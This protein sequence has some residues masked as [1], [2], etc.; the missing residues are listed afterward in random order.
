MTELYNYGPINYAAQTADDFFQDLCLACLRRGQELTPARQ[1]RYRVNAL[2]RVRHY[3]HEKRPSLPFFRERSYTPSYG[4]DPLDFIR[5]LGLSPRDK[6]FLCYL[7]QER[8][9]G[10]RLRTVRLIQEFY[11][12]KRAMSYLILRRFRNYFRM[13]R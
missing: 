3:H 6:A 2:Y 13:A 5:D 10:N 7:Y 1:A 11:G 12:V 4:E 8:E 9:T